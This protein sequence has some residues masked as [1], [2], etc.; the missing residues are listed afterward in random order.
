MKETKTY[1]VKVLQKNGSTVIEK[2][3][4]TFEKAKEYMSMYR[5][6]HKYAKNNFISRITEKNYGTI[7]TSW[8]FMDNKWICIG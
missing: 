2:T 6:R 4:S 1:D 5:S 8:Q 3:F 7:I